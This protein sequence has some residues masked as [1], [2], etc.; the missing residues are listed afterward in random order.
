MLNIYYEDTESEDGY[1]VY[2]ITEYAI[3][4]VYIDKDIDIF[5]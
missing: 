4:A 5:R 3:L 2:G 1:S